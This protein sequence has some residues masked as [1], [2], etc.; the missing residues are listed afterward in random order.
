M[1]M[2]RLIIDSVPAK[3]GIT[4]QKEEIEME[5]PPADLEIEQP[6]AE[7]NI[8]S[9]PA[10]LTIDQTRA[11]ENLNLK[12]FEK[13]NAEAAQKGA[14]ACSEFIAKTVREGKEMAAIEKKTGNVMARQAADVSPPDPFG[15]FSDF[16]PA[17][18]LVDIDCIPSKLTV[19][20]EARK[21]SIEAAAHKPVWNYTPGKVQIDMMQDPKVTISVDD[22]NTE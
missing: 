21:P 1:Q 14:E 8:E 10:K 3:I 11:W 6:P 4:F 15:E 17:Q 12:S 16:L 20:I 22:G 9:T 13:L 2:P 5:Q 7:L 18:F 19:D